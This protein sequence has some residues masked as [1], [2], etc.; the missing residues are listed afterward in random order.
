MGAAGEGGADHSN[1]G[2]EQQRCGC[3]RLL[4]AAARLTSFFTQPIFIDHLSC[5]GHS[6]SAL[7]DTQGCDTL[8]FSGKEFLSVWKTVSS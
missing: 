5:G 2:H 3:R 4:P 7:R 1:G 8:P 6:T